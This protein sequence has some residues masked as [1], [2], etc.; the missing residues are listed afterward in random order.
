MSD[1]RRCEALRGWVASTRAAS[2]Q[3]TGAATG[4][5]P[6]PRETTQACEPPATSGAAARN[7]L[8]PGGSC[9]VAT[10]AFAVGALDELVEDA[11]ARP[12]DAEATAAVSSQQ[13]PSIF[14]LSQFYGWVFGDWLFDPVRW[15]PQ[16]SRAVRCAT[17]AVRA[18]ALG[19]WRQE[20]AQR[21][22]HAGGALGASLRA[23]AAA[24]DPR[25]RHTDSPAF[26]FLS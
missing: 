16:V 17:R 10:H 26:A 24:C 7:V 11:L 25:E 19:E 2:E 13:R 6:L 9:G 4:A 8:S 3:S 20:P 1:A 18:C 15:L 5:S 21:A 23:A 22:T 12:G 14:D